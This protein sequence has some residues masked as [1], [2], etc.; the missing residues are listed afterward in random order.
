MTLRG[1]LQAL[2]LICMTASAAWWFS[3]FQKVGLAMG[4]RVE[5]LT[6]DVWPC[7]LYTTAPCQVAYSVAE[8]AG[9]LSFRPF[10]TWIGLGLFALGCFVS[11]RKATP[12]YQPPPRERQEPRF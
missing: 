3:F 9:Y 1:S 4:V 2:G 5:A 12:N 11:A 6:R 10:L 8:I 7:L